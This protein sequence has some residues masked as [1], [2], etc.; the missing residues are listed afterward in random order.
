M[1]RIAGRTTCWWPWT[2]TAPWPPSWG[3]P[4]TRGR[5]PARPAFAGLT[6]CRAR[7]RHSSPDGPSPA[8]GQV[9]SP[10]EE[11][12]LIGSHGAE[13]W[14]GPGL[15]GADPRRCA[16]STPR[17]GPH[18][19]RRHRGSA[20]H[21]AGGQAGRRG[22]AHPPGRRRRGRGRRRSRTLAAA[23][24]PGR[25]PQERKAGPGNLRGER[26]QGRGRH[27]LRQASGASAVLFAG[28]DTTD[29]DALARWSQ[30]TS[31]SR[32]ASISP[33][34]SSGWRLRSTWPRLLEVLL[35]ERSLAVAEEDP[36]G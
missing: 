26:V 23:G 28:D 25:L 6:C 11:T 31:A 20:G 3:T 5:S 29:E 30:A 9:A 17:R 13:A 14:L 24:P 15:G 33:R 36:Q 27:F 1:R 16:E 2:S 4:T 32:W 35:Q 10:P 21:H 12:L 19:P 8:C 22:A 7:R 34:R 18:H